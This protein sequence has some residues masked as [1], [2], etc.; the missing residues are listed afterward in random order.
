M[1]KDAVELNIAAMR[2]VIKCIHD[3]KLE[4]EYS[5]TTLEECID[6]LLAKKEKNGF[7]VLESQNMPKT[8]SKDVVN[9]ILPEGATF[10]SKVLSATPNS[11]TK[12]NVDPPQPMTI[13]LANMKGKEL[14]FF[15]KE[16]IDEHGLLIDPISSAL[17]LLNDSA[18]L[19]LDAIR[20]LNNSMHKEE[21]EDEASRKWRSCVLLLEQLKM[22]PVDIR[23][24]MIEEARKLAFDLKEKI[25][26][27]IKT[28]TVVIGFLLF[29]N[30]Y[31]VNPFLNDNEL[32]GFYASGSSHRMVVR[33]CQA[34][35][36]SE[37]KS[38]MLP[39]THCLFLLLALI[40]KT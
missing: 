39:E 10:P 35:G 8:Q 1:Q 17:K 21:N 26:T 32:L 25:K 33:L 28:P 2:T 38:G 20:G 4:S 27:G 23:E 9:Q 15:L 5:P 3:H 29:T 6:Q 37:R 19:V 16:H 11:S 7:T 13:V 34:L 22:R 12:S 18:G 24:E 31:R 30:M 36:I 14:L 40:I